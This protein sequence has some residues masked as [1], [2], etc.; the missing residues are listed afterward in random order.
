MPSDET[1]H[2]QLPVPPRAQ[3][4]YQPACA[5][6]ALVMTAGMTPR[7]EGV[8]QHVGRVGGEVSI[9]AAREAAA[10]AASNAV[11]AVAELLG[12]MDRIDRALRMTV[13]VNAVPGFSEHSTVADGASERLFELLGD[14]GAVVR[15]AVGVSSLPGGACVEVELTCSR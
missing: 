14:R 15:S 5:T 10:I 6:E 3:G 11:S 7:V 8:L 4:R 12:S 9:E 13:Y 2:A 1:D